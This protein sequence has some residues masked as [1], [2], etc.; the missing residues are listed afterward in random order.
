MSSKVY[1][2][3]PASI[4]KFDRVDFDFSCVFACSGGLFA[5]F[6]VA[7]MYTQMDVF[8]STAPQLLFLSKTNGSLNNPRRS[9][10]R[11]KFQTS[12]G[13]IRRQLT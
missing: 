8:L 13:E 7:C 11:S 9:V 2:W 1:A 10:S 6:N 3:N 5:C 4:E 12:E